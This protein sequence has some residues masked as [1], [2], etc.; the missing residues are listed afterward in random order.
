MST[1]PTSL[2]IRRPTHDQISME[3]G[4]QSQPP[5]EVSDSEPTRPPEAPTSPPTRRYLKIT[6]YRILVTCVTVGFGTWKAI[7]SSRGEAAANTLD[8]I[9]GI[10]VALLCVWYLSTYV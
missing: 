1:S 8:W 9:L 4:S 3:N 6:I 7:S 5:A 2:L 10:I